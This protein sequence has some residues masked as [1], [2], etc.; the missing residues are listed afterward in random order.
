MPVNN[1][2]LFQKP[3]RRVVA[4][5]STYQIPPEEAESAGKDP[6]AEK[7]QEMVRSL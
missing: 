1:T 6:T 7:E 4:V 3:L 2:F 5:K